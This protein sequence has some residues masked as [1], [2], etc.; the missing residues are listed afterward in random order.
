MLLT[1]FADR[2]KSLARYKR[3][4]CHSH[5]FLSD[6]SVKLDESDTYVTKTHFQLHSSTKSVAWK[7]FESNHKNREKQTSFIHTSHQIE[8]K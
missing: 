3:S 2:F 8:P 1:V 6:P 5:L 7:V 4:D